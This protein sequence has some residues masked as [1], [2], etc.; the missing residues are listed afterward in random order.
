MKAE[1]QNLIHGLTFSRNII[2]SH[3]LFADDSL[4]FTRASTEDC[5]KL[6]AIFECYTSASGQLFNYDKSSMFFGGNVSDGQIE[7]IKRI[8]QLN[9]VS[10]HERYLRLPSMVGRKRTSFFNNIKLKVL[11]KISSWQHKFFSSGGK[12]VLIKT[13]AQVVPAYAMSVFKIPLAVSNDI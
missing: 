9:V 13:V 1:R 6:K 7:A 2:I 4:V 10:R 12:E 11:S 5:N 3:L 8:F